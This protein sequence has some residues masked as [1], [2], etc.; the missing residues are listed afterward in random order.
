[1]GDNGEMCIE[2]IVMNRDFQEI[3]LNR[4]I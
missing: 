4:S 2:N 3:P 1:V